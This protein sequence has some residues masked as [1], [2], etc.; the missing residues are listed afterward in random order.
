MDY[1]KEELKEY[2][3]DFLVD[4]GS[5]WVAANMDDLHHYA[6]NEDYYIIGYNKAVEWMGTKAFEIIHHV[7][8]YENDNFGECTTDLSEP[9][10]VVNMYAYIIGE[11]I[12]NEWKDKREAI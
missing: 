6:F 2:F 5:K 1:K 9:E 8:D 12:V 3:T 7:K 11:E 4:R 10:K